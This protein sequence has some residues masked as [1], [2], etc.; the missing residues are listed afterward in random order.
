MVAHSI[1]WWNEPKTHGSLLRRPVDS[2]LFQYTVNHMTCRVPSVQAVSTG[3]RGSLRFRPLPRRNTW[4]ADGMRQ[5]QNKC[6]TPVSNTFTSALRQTSASRGRS[7]CRF[8][9]SVK[10]VTFLPTF[11]SL[12]GQI[13]WKVTIR[14][15][16]RFQEMLINVTLTQWIL[17]IELKWCQ[18]ISKW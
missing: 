7:F 3:W 8:I 16:W 6:W 11:V 13:T 4:H 9:T 14:F 5:H 18:C 15:Q 2:V 12:V 1:R 17:S 10:A